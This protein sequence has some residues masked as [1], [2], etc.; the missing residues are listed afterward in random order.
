[1]YNCGVL[2]GFIYW[3]LSKSRALIGELFKQM[4]AEVI[5][6][7]FL[8]LPKQEIESSTL[9][10]HFLNSY[11]PVFLMEEGIDATLCTV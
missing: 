1:M 11:P 6:L 10:P 8:L 2:T 4:Q 3:K 9:S 7:Q 5:K